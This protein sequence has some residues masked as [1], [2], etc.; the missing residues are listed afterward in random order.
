MAQEQHDSCRKVRREFAVVVNFPV[1]GNDEAAAGRGHGIVDLLFFFSSRRRHTRY[2]RDWSSDVCSSD[3]ASTASAAD[4]DVMVAEALSYLHGIREWA[5]WEI[6]ERVA[7]HWLRRGRIE[8][9]A[10][11]LGFLEARNIRHVAYV[12]SRQRALDVIKA[13]SNAEAWMRRGA[14]FDPEIGR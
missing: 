8:P 6:V 3:L 5:A 2:W 7:V 10:V 1:V 4:A 11:L 12:R 9:A 14:S 13:T